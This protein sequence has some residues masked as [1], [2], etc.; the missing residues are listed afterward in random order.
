MLRVLFRKRREILGH[1]SLGENRVCLTNRNAGATVN[2]VYGVDVELRDLRK[3]RFI[4]TRMN[5][6]N[7]ANFDTFLILCTTFDDYV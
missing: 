4:V 6:I 3:L 1:L 7:R 5:A 2:A